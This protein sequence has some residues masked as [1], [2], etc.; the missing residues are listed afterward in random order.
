MSLGR[1][2]C[3]LLRGCFRE[4]PFPGEGGRALCISPRRP[5]QRLPGWQFL[6]LSNQSQTPSASGLSPKTFLPRGV[7]GAQEPGAC[8]FGP[9]ASAWA[10]DLFR[11]HVCS[12]CQIHGGPSQGMQASDKQ[13]TLCPRPVQRGHS[14]HFTPPRSAGPC[15]EAGPL[16]R[17]ARGNWRRAP[18]PS[19]PAPPTLLNGPA[20]P[21]PLWA[22]P[23]FGPFPGPT[24]SIA[25]PFPFWFL[26]P[27]QPRP[28][29]PTPF[30]LWACPHLAPSTH[31]ALP[32]SS[33]PTWPRP[34]FD[35]T[36]PFW[37][38]FT[39]PAPLNP[40]LCPR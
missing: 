12:E 3:A 38:L 31:L 17:G 37:P 5:V 19:R 16:G 35:P 25:P 39:L 8:C 9:H 18:A 23:P 24:L 15:W 30:P 22:R 34:I 13:V 6:A 26:S 21:L 10:P 2:E 14:P 36:P 28:S 7:C 20:L 32:T 4:A 29:E 1:P 11:T 27:C 40:P 33:L